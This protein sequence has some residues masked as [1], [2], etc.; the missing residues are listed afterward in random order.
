MTRDDALKLIPPGWVE[1]NA[2]DLTKGYPRWEVDYDDPHEGAVYANPPPKPEP[3][4][5]PCGKMVVVFNEDGFCHGQPDP[6]N[7]IRQKHGNSLK[8][9]AN[10][11]WQLDFDTREWVEVLDES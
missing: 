4:R 8:A 7:L 2:E 11:K 6:V 5:V 3:R 9:V 10:T 1:C